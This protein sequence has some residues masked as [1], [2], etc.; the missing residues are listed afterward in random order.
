LPE[1]VVFFN[2]FEKIMNNTALITKR[3]AGRDLNPHHSGGVC[4][5]ISFYKKGE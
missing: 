3:L 1:K 2:L 4:R 5:K